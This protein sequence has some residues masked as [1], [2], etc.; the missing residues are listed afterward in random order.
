M[1]VWGGI[2]VVDVMIGWSGEGVLGCCI[3]IYRYF[4]SLDFLYETTF[5]TFY[6]SVLL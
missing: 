5:V 4:V 3:F 6:V 1:G 2:G